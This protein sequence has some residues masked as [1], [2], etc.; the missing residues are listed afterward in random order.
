[1]QG[2]LAVVQHHQIRT[3][4]VA[5]EFGVK[6]NNTDTVQKE[7]GSE[8]EQ[9]RQHRQRKPSYYCRLGIKPSTI[10]RSS[11]QEVGCMTA[12][13]GEEYLASAAMPSVSVWMCARSRK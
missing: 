11:Q 9:R 13:R 3:E 4:A 5:E 2:A 10:P 12:C 6:K 1:M 8:E 7:Q